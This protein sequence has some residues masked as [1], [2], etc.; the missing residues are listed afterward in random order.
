MPMSTTPEPTNKNPGQIPNGVSIAFALVTF[1]LF[2]SG[3]SALAWAVIIV[4][5]LAVGLWLG[6]KSRK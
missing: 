1:F 4:G 6:L 3:Q 5:G 2:Y